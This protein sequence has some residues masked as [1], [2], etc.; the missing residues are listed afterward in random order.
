MRRVLVTGGAGFIGAHLVRAL[1]RRGDVVRVLDNL[2]AGSAENLSRALDVPVAWVESV[3]ARAES[4]VAPLTESCEVLVGDL[5]DPEAVARACEKVAVVF[6]QAALRSVP[7][8][9]ADPTGTHSVN[10]TGTLSLLEAARASGV[11]RVVFASSSSINGAKTTRRTPDA[12]R[13]ST[14]LN[15]SHVRISYAVFCL[16]KKNIDNKT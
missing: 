8:S 9:I 12:D 11:R 5:L 13:K 10:V 2:V 6:H 14:R 7:R 15:S 16:T 4:A 3:L 1:V